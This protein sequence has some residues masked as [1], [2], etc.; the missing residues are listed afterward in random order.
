MQ[1]KNEHSPSEPRIVCTWMERREEKR[2]HIQMIYSREWNINGLLQSIVRKH[3]H[4]LFA[5]NK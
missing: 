5:I 4:D 2:K 1:K 3:F